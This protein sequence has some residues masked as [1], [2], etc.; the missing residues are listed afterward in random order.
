MKKVWN[1]IMESKTLSE[2][3]IRTLIKILQDSLEHKENKEKSIHLIQVDDGC[4]GAFI[5]LDE[6]EQVNPEDL[7]RWIESSLEHGLSFKRFS[8]TEEEYNEIEVWGD[9]EDEFDESY[10]KAYDWFNFNERLENA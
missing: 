5:R 10:F 4:E 8:V 9:E 6:W 7:K 1:Q 3:E 2:S